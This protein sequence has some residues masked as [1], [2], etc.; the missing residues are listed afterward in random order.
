SC[1]PDP[2]AQ[3]A[4]TTCTASV[5]GSGAG[6]GNPTPTGT[7]AFTV[8]PSGSGPFSPGSCGL[9]DHNVANQSECSVTYTPSVIG[10][11]THTITATYS[12]DS[13]YK[14]NTPGNYGLTVSG[15]ATSLSV[16]GFVSPVTAGTTGTFTVT[17]KDANNHTAVGYT[18]TVHFT[19]SDG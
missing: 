17:A 4:A 9:A 2:V 16:T 18:G 7:V 3:S 11:G 15:A 5:V 14:D 19:S 6:G 12:G 8:S 1:S 10:S 13:T